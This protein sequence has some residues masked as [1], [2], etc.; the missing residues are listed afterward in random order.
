MGQ[1]SCKQKKTMEIVTYSSIIYLSDYFWK[2]PYLNSKEVIKYFYETVVTKHLLEKLPQ[3]IAEDCV[4]NTG[5]QLIPSKPFLKWI[6]QTSIT[7]ENNQRF[8]IL[9]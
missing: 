3:Y 8:L 2:V 4:V 1:Q 6:N 9:L 7:I 5:E